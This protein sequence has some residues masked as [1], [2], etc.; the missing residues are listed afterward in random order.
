MLAP[1]L[2]VFMAPSLRVFMDAESFFR[3][4]HSLLSSVQSSVPLVIVNDK[5]WMRWLNGVYI[6]PDLVLTM[7]VPGTQ[8]EGTPGLL[9]ERD[10]QVEIRNAPASVAWASR[11][12]TALVR[13]EVRGEVLP[14]L[15]LAPAAGNVVAVFHDELYARVSFGGTD[16][17]TRHDAPVTHTVSFGAPLFDE[18]WRLVGLHEG[19]AE[20]AS[21]LAPI[22][23]IL[24]E[25]E[26]E[27][28][29]L[30][31][32][33]AAVHRLVRT[34]SVSIDLPE[35]T[36]AS[37]ERAVRWDPDADEVLPARERR[38]ALR[39]A[40][41]EDLRRARGHA[42]ATGPEQEAI[43]AILG[44]PPFALDALA[45]DVLLAFATAARWFDG[46]VEGLPEQEALELAIHRRRQRAALDAIIGP[47]FAPR[48]SEVEHL[49]AWLFERDRPPLVLRGPGGIGKS[50]LLAFFVRKVCPPARFAWLDFDR[51]D[52]SA[53]EETIARVVD[54]HLAW[55]PGAGTLIVVLDSFETSVTYGYARLNP[56]LDALARRFPDLAVV[57]GSRTSAPLLKIEGRKAVEYEV[58]GLDPAVAARWLADEKV[59]GEIVAEAAAVA[60]GVPLNLRLARDLLAG[61]SRDEARAFLAELPRQ[62]VTG[63][64][65]RRILRRLDD[66]SLKPYAQ[67][68]MVPRRLV[69]ELLERILEK[70]GGAP[71]GGASRLFEA[72]RREVTLLD[73]ESV[74]TVRPDLR[75]TILPLLAAED[76]ALV[77]AIDTSAAG[78]WA[79][80]AAGDNAAAADAIYHHLRLSDLASAGKLWHTGVEPFL[81][82]YTLEEIP[83]ASRAWLD[84]RLS[85][86]S[87]EQRVEDLLAR[88]RL[89]DAR[90]ALADQPTQGG[91]TSRNAR[92]R[93]LLGFVD[94]AP[95][96]TSENFEGLESYVLGHERPAYRIRYGSF[97]ALRSPW[98]DLERHRDRLAGA[99]GCVGRLRL[100]DDG[101]VLGT[102]TLVGPRLLLTTRSAVAPFVVGTGTLVRWIPDRRVEIDMRAE[103][104]GVEERYRVGRAVLVHPHWDIALIEALDDL[105]ARSSRAPVPL[106]TFEPAPRS[107][108]VAIGHPG[109]AGLELAHVQ[110]EIFGDVIDVKR[111]MPG[112]LLDRSDEVSFGHQVLAGWDDCSTLGADP[113]GALID[114]ETGAL[115]G[116][117]FA[118][119][120]F[121]HSAFVPAW[122]LA[123]DPEVVRS[124]VLITGTPGPPP[125]WTS[126]WSSPPTARQ[127]LLDACVAL[128]QDDVA[129]ARALVDLVPASADA[130][131]HVD[132]TLVEVACLVR[133]AGE[134]R[135]RAGDLLEQLI[136]DF[137]P[138]LTPAD[139]AAIV[140]TRLRLAVDADAERDLCLRR[141]ANDMTSMDKLIPFR[142]LAPGHPQRRVIWPVRDTPLE[143]SLHELEQRV[144]RAD[145]EC[146]RLAK[147]AGA[148][149]DRLLQLD[150]AART[151][152]DARALAAALVGLPRERA[153]RPSAYLL[154]K[155][156]V[157][158]HPKLGWSPALQPLA[159]Y[160][161]SAP[162][163]PVDLRPEPLA[164][165]LDA[166]AKSGRLGAYLNELIRLDTEVA[167]TAGLLHLL[168]PL[169]IESMLEHRFTDGTSRGGEH[170]T[171]G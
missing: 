69:P 163:R 9:A 43:D 126:A 35:R 142:V 33:I 158:R 4:G 100:L 46:V 138:A 148:H 143:A 16:G 140:A 103:G 149:G 11:A 133:G 64:L 85:R 44:G 116:V 71:S 112:K 114:P 168:T 115:V 67:W 38:Q 105:G 6:T 117:R 76:E 104:D 55:Q 156:D 84:S 17:G 135:A 169:P 102:A 164:E 74:L 130:R 93:L 91:G 51:P 72:L 132:R 81:R 128:R 25:I 77:R 95:E 87:V 60:G 37:L 57:V 39:G 111:L 159:A 68:T 42:P 62:L 24:R 5:E 29:A 145:V 36:S 63:Y 98:K 89:A 118:S 125:A 56:A 15:A 88:G 75:N 123:C 147:W 41:L 92:R 78:F 90:A 19:P 141:S 165:W 79:E 82:G 129:R 122:E 170:D 119:Q 14:E 161:A 50:A 106:A 83:E 8:T 53:D 45:L 70:V 3:R 137:A 48:A 154:E 97:E 59:P 110:R 124:G 65:Y 32:E 49:T 109:G 167:W 131:S 18:S 20:Q 166:N 134:E 101:R 139:A 113:G 30:W 99:I 80:R 144:V 23:T 52:V 121:G 31:E 73:G 108:V 40:S 7:D 61:R 136:S 96:I 152:G 26:Q 28:P 21:A 150:F 162:Q 54:E 1:P 120:V 151:A 12:R 58:P 13:A 66:P 22:A 127:H 86:Q 160:L 27:A 146:R 94:D 47:R 171:E 34:T 107:D 155:L 157:E 2:R 153:D 10:L